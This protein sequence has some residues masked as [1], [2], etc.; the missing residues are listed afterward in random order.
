MLLRL[1]LIENHRC[2]AVDVSQDSLSWPQL[3]QRFRP[4]VFSCRYRS[5]RPRD[6]DALI[7]GCMQA[8]RSHPRLQPAS[9][10]RPFQCLCV[11]RIFV[12]QVMQSAKGAHKA[13]R[14]LSNACNNDTTPPRPQ[15][16]PALT[17]HLENACTIM[18]EG[19]AYR[20]GVTSSSQTGR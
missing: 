12:S 4:P 9:R 17:K 14:R 6:K 7:E 11:L 13:S 16:T 8:P 2:A 15:K 5:P 10:D 19:K 3:L 1:L 18:D 20:L